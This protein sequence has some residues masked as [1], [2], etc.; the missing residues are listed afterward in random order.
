MQVS[1]HTSRQASIRTGS[2]PQTTYHVPQT[3]DRQT[4]DASHVALGWGSGGSVRNSSDGVR[5]PPRVL[6]HL[7]VLRDHFCGVPLTV[8]EVATHM[9]GAPSKNQITSTREG[10]KLAVTRGL[11]TMTNVRPVAFTPVP[12]DR[13]QP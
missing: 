2:R 12:T 1:M 7:A 6:A 8:T 5:E 4:A 10:L 3:T 13:W 9:H 11:A